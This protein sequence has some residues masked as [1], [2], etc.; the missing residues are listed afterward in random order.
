MRG[1]LCQALSLSLGA[2]SP[3]CPCF[4]GVGGVGVGIQHRLTARAP[5]GWRCVLWGWREGVPRASAGGVYRAIARGACPPLAA[6]PAPGAG[7][8]GSL[9]MYPGRGH[10]GAGA[11]HCPFG[12]HALRGTACRGGG[13]RLSRG[14]GD[15]SP[16]WG[17]CG[18]RRCPSP[19]RP[20]LRASSQA[21]LPVFPGR[22]WCGRGA[23]STGP[24]TCALASRRFVPWGWREGVPGGGCAAPL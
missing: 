20:S 14:G 11:R 4:L 13:W 16:L 2:A 6:L 5:V 23:P 3:R 8:W 19:G 1:V 9:P 7:S 24:T 15:L 22:G 10:A 17:A 18:V 21:T 12:V